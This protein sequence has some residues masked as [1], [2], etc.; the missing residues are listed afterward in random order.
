MSRG[1]S[2]GRSASRQDYACDAYDK[3]GNKGPRQIASHKSR[4]LQVSRH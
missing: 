2:M 4:S 3:T 1:G